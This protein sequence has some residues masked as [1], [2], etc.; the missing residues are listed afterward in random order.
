MKDGVKKF[1][2]IVEDRIYPLIFD[3]EEAHI[4][5]ALQKEINILFYQKNAYYQNKLDKETIY[6]LLLVDFLTSKKEN[7]FEDKIVL[8]EKVKHMISKIDFVL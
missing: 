2:F 7:D 3:S 8:A 4:A 5:F 6:F 1:S